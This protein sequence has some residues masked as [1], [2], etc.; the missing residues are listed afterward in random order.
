MALPPFAILCWK[1][2]PALSR[3]KTDADFHFEPWP[4]EGRGEGRFPREL[5][6]PSEVA[7]DELGGLN[8]FGF[9]TARMQGVEMMVAGQNKIGLRRNGTVHKFVIIRIGCN[10]SKTKV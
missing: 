1:S 3:S 7:R 10:H 8:R 5:V 4:P 6:L 2:K 9:I